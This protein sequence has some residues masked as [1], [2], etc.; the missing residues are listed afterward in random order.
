MSI[1]R[2]H[3]SNHVRKHTRLTSHVPPTRKAWSHDHSDDDVFAPL[4][5]RYS[6]VWFEQITSPTRTYPKCSDTLENET[7]EGSASSIDM[8][9][10]MVTHEQ[11]VKSPYSRN[12]TSGDLSERRGVYAGYRGD[13]TPTSVRW[14]GECHRVSYGLIYISM[15]VISL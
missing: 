14:E 1:Q 13:R 15:F 12:Q 10:N 3:H 8:G 2:D 9:D 5:K 7:T 11:E 6:Y 4:K